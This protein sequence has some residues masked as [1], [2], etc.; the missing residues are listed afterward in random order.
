[1]FGSSIYLRDRPAFTGGS[2]QAVYEELWQRGRKGRLRTRAFLAAATLVLCGLLVNAVFGVVMAVVV[3]AADTLVHWRIYSASRVWRL[4]LRGEQRMNRFLR[5][6]LERRGHRVLHARTVPEHG[7]ADALVVG[8]GG[9][10]LV[11]NEAWSPG[12]E[13][14][15]HGGRLF[16]DGRTQSKLVAGLTARAEAAAAAISR[17][18]GTPVTVTPVLAVHG[19]KLARTPF[20]AD[21]IV[22]APPLK[23]IRWMRRNPTAD[24]SAEEIEAITRA[25]VR[26]LPVG[27]HG[28]AHAAA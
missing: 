26:A 27:S 10:W 20:T 11:H 22:F 17:A 3:A 13:V 18:A 7:T 28:S 9:V 23:L 21:G 4:G 25:A 24:R 16:I 6:T 2:P 5:Y 14:S 12:A 15:Q 1:M 19:G 8:P